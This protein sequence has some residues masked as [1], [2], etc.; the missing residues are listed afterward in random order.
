MVANYAGNE[1]RAKS[2]EQETK[3]PSRKWDVSDFQ[4]C[5]D[6]GAVDYL[7][8]PVNRPVLHS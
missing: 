5:L 8:K 7:H 6:S 2:F 3:I 1:E 4:A